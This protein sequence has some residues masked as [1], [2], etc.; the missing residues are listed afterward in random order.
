[1]YWDVKTSYFPKKLMKIRVIVDLSLAL[2][3]RILANLVSHLSKSSR[4]LSKQSLV[5]NA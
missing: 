5:F 2:L 4:P 3:G 1:M